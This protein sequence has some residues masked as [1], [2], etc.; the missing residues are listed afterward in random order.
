[1]SKFF[2]LEADEGSNSEDSNRE[3]KGKI[4]SKNNDK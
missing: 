4:I 1:M 3:V 2:E